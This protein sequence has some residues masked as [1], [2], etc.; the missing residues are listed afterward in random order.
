MNAVVP[1]LTLRELEAMTPDFSLVTYG[2]CLERECLL[3]ADAEGT[4]CFVSGNPLDE[5]VFT[6]AAHKIPGY[7]RLACSHPLELK[8]MLSRLEAHQ[9]AI[10]QVIRLE[11]GA[12]SQGFESEEISLRSIARDDS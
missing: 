4:R 1:S 2:E 6:W 3:V 12:A 7:F 9:Q 11:Q 5:A 8:A 10:S